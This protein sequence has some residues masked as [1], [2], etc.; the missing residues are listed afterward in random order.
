MKHFAAHI[1][2][3]KE[4]FRRLNKK[5]FSLLTASKVADINGLVST[6]ELHLCVNV[7]DI[8]QGSK[9]H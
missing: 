8:V 2:G 7:L 1:G 3:L 6:V 5:N 4:A 9:K